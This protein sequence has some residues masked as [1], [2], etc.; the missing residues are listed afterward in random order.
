MSGKVGFSTALHVSRIMFKMLVT[1]VSSEVQ[2]VCHC[3]IVICIWF[4]SNWVR[5][6]IWI[7]LAS[8]NCVWNL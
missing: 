8:K 3:S 2:A 1:R 6:L 7:E 4:S 5:S